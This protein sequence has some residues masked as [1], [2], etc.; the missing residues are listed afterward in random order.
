[1]ALDAVLADASV[2]W[3]ASEREKRRYF[4]EHLPDQRDDEYPRHVY[5]TPPRVTVRYFPDKLPIG[6][7]ATGRQH[8]FRYASRRRWTC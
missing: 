7:D 4:Q 6:V 8:A 2:N 1:M 5:G 3:L